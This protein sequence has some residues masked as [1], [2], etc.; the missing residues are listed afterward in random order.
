M[1]A[2]E[3]SL[4]DPPVRDTQAVAPPD[5]TIELSAL[6]RAFQVES[7]GDGNRMAGVNQLAAMA[8]V[9][10]NLARPMSGI[11]T[12]EGR[13]LEVGCSLL[14]TGPMVTS[15]ILDEVVTP[16]RRCQDNLLVWS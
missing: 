7:L 4:P 3:A 9:L 16:V 1:I 10:A 8:I 5:Y 13:R 6:Q 14:A 11:V 12:R 2:V 15:A